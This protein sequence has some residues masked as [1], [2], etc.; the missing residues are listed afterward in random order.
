MT[1]HGRKS[2]SSCVAERSGKVLDLDYVLELLVLATT[3]LFHCSQCYNNV[4]DDNLEVVRFLVSSM[5]CYYSVNNTFSGQSC[6]LD[7][8]RVSGNWL[9][10]CI[11]R[12]HAGVLARRGAN[13]NEDADDSKPGKLYCVTTHDLADVVSSRVVIAFINITFLRL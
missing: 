13:R 1:T 4:T 12:A 8:R 7:D 10:P 2:K 11:D 6:C 5:D 9:R 3:F